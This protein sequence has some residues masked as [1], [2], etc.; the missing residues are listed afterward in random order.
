M[1]ADRRTRRRPRTRREAISGRSRMKAVYLVSTLALGAAAAGAATAQESKPVLI[2]VN[3]AIQ[4]QVGRDT[5]D[6]AKMAIEEINAKGGVLGR[7]LEM[8]PPG[9]VG[10]PKEG[11]ASVNKLTG[12]NN[13]NV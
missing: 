13:V 1:S 9:G 3:T 10:S 7:K 5:I 4:L 11:V 6:G 8:A 12:D 2:G